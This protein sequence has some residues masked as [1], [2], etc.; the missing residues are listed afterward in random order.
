MSPRVDRRSTPIPQI[1]WRVVGLSSLAG[2]ILA[3][4]IL[5]IQIFGEGG[6]D[7]Q[8]VIVPG[9]FGASADA[10][11]EDFDDDVHYRDD[12]LVGHDGQFF[13]S[14]ARDPWHL[15]DVADH[16]DRPTYRLGRP[17]LSWV[18]WALH[19]L[20]GGYGLAWT[21]VGVG[22]AAAFAF[23]IAGGVMLNLTA[24]RPQLAAIFPVLPGSIATLA[25]S[26]A[27]V[28]SLVLLLGAMAAT[29]KERT[30]GAAAMGACAL[31]AKESVALP[32]VIFLG[33]RAI[34]RLGDH[35]R[36]VA[37]VVRALLRSPE[38]RIASASIIPWLLWSVWLRIELGA[39][40]QV[41]EF[42]LPFEGLVD[43][44]RLEWSTGHQLIAIAT[45]PFTYLAAI[46][47]LYR[48]RSVHRLR[49]LW[50]ALL[51]QLCFS[52]LFGVNVVGLDYNATRTMMPLLV[53]AL[54]VGLGSMVP[55]TE[56][57]TPS[58]SRPRPTPA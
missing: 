42:G 17:L 3:I 33:V 18:T 16:L 15:D 31:L 11:E 5:G 55:D 41:V 7:P 37:A 49:P 21:L 50:W 27:D 36:S 54:I 34:M 43:A 1:D 24:G 28:L 20:G 29:I 8:S 45:V 10:F 40:T 25:L 23:G 57:Q 12:R 30:W 4:V 38:G 47:A 26:T 44:W 48:G 32:L 52:T 46:W 53:L 9:E 13:Y 39:E 6:G 22:V 2:T 14:V 56:D 51:G 35:D 19:P 58:F